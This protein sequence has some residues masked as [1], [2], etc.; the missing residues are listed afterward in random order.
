[1]SFSR[2]ATMIVAG[3]LTLAA[4]ASVGCSPRASLADS[5]RRSA[6]ADQGETTASAAETASAAQTGAT[7]FEEATFDDVKFEMSLDEPFVDSMITPQVAAR[8]DKLIRIRGYMFPTLRKAG[9]KQFVLVR[10]NLECCFGPGAALY[11]CILVYLRPDAPAEYS[12]RP[13]TVEGT[14]R[15]DKKQAGRNG[16]VLAIYR[17]DDAVVK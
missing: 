10:D 13:I 8:F 5:D 17:L 16:P 1:M 12:V 3:T 14:F 15:F 9:L 7:T 11:D 4:A 2:A 6:D